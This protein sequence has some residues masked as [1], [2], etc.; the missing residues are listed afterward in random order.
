MAPKAGSKQ[1]IINVEAKKGVTAKLKVGPASSKVEEERIRS[2]NDKQD[3]DGDYVLYW[4][5]A[6]V[7]AEWNHA[8]QYAKQEANRLQLPLVCCFGVTKY[9]EANIRHYQFMLEG[10]A[11]LQAQLKKQKIKLIVKQQ[12]PFKLAADLGKR[13]AVVVTDMGYLN[14]QRKWRQDLAKALKVRLMQVESCAVVPVEVASNKR[15]FAAR[16][17]RPKILKELPKYLHKLTAVSVKKSSLS[18]KV[19]VK[20]DA[21]LTKKGAI[22]KFL[23]SLK[24]LDR[25]VPAAPTFKG[26]AVAAQK[27]LKEFVKNRLAHYGEERNE[28][29]KKFCSDLSPYYH[30][31]QLSPLDAAVAVMESRG[32]K[33]GKEGFVEESV[34][35]RE[36]SLN[37]THFEPKYDQFSALP[38]WAKKTLSQHAKDKHTHKY[39]LKQLEK[40]ETNDDVWNAAQDEMV[41]TGKMAN[42]LRMYWGKK[43]VEWAPT[44]ETAFKWLVYLNNKYELDGRDSNSY[45]GIAWCFG[46]HDRPWQKNPRFGMVRYMGYNGIRSKFD[47]KSYIAMV[48]G[49]RNKY[50]MKRSSKGNK[51][52]EKKGSSQ[53]KSSTT[54]KRPAAA[55]TGGPKKRP[56]A[57]K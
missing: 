25:S 29:T 12:P 50:G 39:S 2:L 7:R 53:K 13:A 17:I 36:L 28:P 33:T 56:A 37:F 52:S 26:G 42:Y 22:D 11:D 31:G 15:E 54:R 10:V 1:T 18:T 38:P 19:K 8:L 34:V 16:T 5:Q 3:G 49:M 40:G 23:K 32:P 41:L 44:H 14:I 20:G 9:P 27:Q 43:V 48:D 21:D 47:M 45:A 4:V 24:G 35:R 51:G 46:N 57:S 6:T 30:F 55:Q